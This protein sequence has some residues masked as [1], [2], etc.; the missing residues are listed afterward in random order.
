MR[1]EG[2]GRPE[3]LSEIHKNYIQKLIADSPF[4]TSNRIAI[5]LKN[6]YEVR[7]IEVLFLGSSLKRGINGEDRRLFTETM[8]R[9][10]KI[11]LN[12][13]SKIRKEIGAM[14]LLQMKLLSISYHQENIRWV[15]SGESYER[16]N[17]KYSQK[18]HVWWAFQL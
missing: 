11:G 1:E 12:F 4:N 9:T 14:Y 2:S 15:A 8:R 5:K 17:T 6:N 10:K 3:K 18:I 13:V 16:T 7:Y